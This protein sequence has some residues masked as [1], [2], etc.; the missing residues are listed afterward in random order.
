M[1][2]PLVA[3]VKD[4]TT[5][6][7]GVPLLEDATGL[8]SAIESKNWAA[9]AIGAVGTALDVLTAVLDPFGAIFA[10]GVGWLM[11]HVGPLKEALDAL[12]GNADEIE[13]HAETWANVAKELEGV[14]AELSD[15]V[16]K[17]L[18]SWSGD[19]A[20]AYRAQADDVS[21]LIS[22]AQK[23]CEGA[24]S[25]VK[26]AGEIVA[27]VRSLVRDTIADLVGHLISWALQVVF[28]LGIGM[29]WVVPQVVTAVAKT[30]SK[31]TSVTTKLVKAMKALMPLLKKAGSLFED[32]GKALKGLKGGKVKAPEKPKDIKSGSPDPKPH[33]KDEGTETAG[34]KGGGS[35]PGGPNQDTHA[36]GAGGKN[37]NDHNGGGSNGDHHQDGDHTSTSGSETGGPGGK[38]PTDP[39]RTAEDPDNRPCLTDP[40]DLSSGEVIFEAIDLD[41]PELLVERVHLSSYR[42][43]HWFGPSWAST[44]DQR[45][46][47]DADGV[48]YFGPNGVILVYPRP[49][50]GAPVLPVEG[51]RWPLAQHEDG[52]F[53]IGQASLGRT[54]RFAG[55]V[56]LLREIDDADGSQTR[57]SYA[58]N[59][60]PTRLAHSSGLQVGF[61]TDAGRVTELR[62]I[63]DGE[64]SDVVVRSY[65]YNAEGRLAEVVNSSGKPLRFD[66]DR[67]GRLTGW[68]DRN[69]VWY[70]YVYDAEGRCVRTVGDRGFFDGAFEYDREAR[71]TRFTD[72]LGHVSEYECNPEGKVVRETDPLGHVTRS[73]WERYGKL[74][75]RTDPLGQTTSFAYDERG[76]LES[77]T[78][79]DGS[80]LRVAEDAGGLTIE[81]DAE[82]GTVLSRFYPG[83][84]APDPFTETLGIARALTSAQAAWTRGPEAPAPADR[85]V[86]GRPRSVLN[87][88]QRD[89]VLGWTVDGSERLRV[90]PSGVRETRRYDAEGN[91]VEH[92]NGA[93]LAERTEYG[94]FDLVT[95]TIDPSGARTS[96][97]YDTELRPVTVTNPLGQ[98]WT[99]RY[100]PAGRLVEE[101]DFD[102]RTLRFGYDAAGRLAWSADG[103]GERTEYGYDGLGNVVE[104]RCPAGTTRFAYDAVGRMTGAGEADVELRVTY[105]GE[106]NVLSESVDGRTL[107]CTHS[108]DGTVRWRTPSGVDSVWTFDGN[109]RPASL[110][111]AGHTVRF[112]HDAGGREISRT[113]DAGFALTQSFD[114]DDNLVGQS[115]QAAGAPP[116]R[117]RFSYRPDGLLTGI[118]DDVTGP[119][120]LVLDAAGRVA[121]VHGTTGRETYRYDPAGNV[122][123]TREPGHG[124][125]AG[126]RRYEKN[127]LVSAGAVSFEHDVCGRVVTRSEGG[128]VWKYLWDGQDRL[129]AVVTPEG[130]H[131]R[132]RY[133]PI[134]R[135]IGKQ[136]VVTSATGARVA[137]ESYEFTWSGA[138]LV[139]QVYVDPSQTRHVTV[140]AHH[141]D[142]DRPV[143]QVERSATLDERFF[144]IVTDLIGRPTD[145]VDAAGS[146]VWHGNA[147]LWGGETGAAA[148]PL[149]FPGQYADAES[150]LHYNLYRYYDPSTG[151]YLSQDPLGLGPA[152]NPAAYVGNP[153]AD[154]D[155]LGL[156][157]GKKGAGGKAKT[158]DRPGGG[159]SAGNIPRKILDWFRKPFK[160]KNPDQPPPHTD[161][162][163]PPPPK[164]G[165]QYSKERPMR[166]NYEHETDPAREPFPG[167]S[168]KRL[169]D[170]QR[171]EH[172]VYLD[173]SGKM[174]NAKDGTLF[175]TSN[176]TDIH[177][178]SGD[179]RAIFTMDRHGNIYASNYQ[180]AGDF[181][182]STLANGQP[183][184][185]AGEL[186]V[187]NGTVTHVNNNSG[188]YQPQLDQSQNIYDEFKSHGIDPPNFGF[189]GHQL[190]GPGG[191]LR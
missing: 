99:Y 138:L 32:A 148:T 1:S 78:R 82:D 117:R 151:R 170:Q 2:N 158:K 12:T 171:E 188:H 154:R 41:L 8:K 27:A 101:T 189:G 119:T 50:V 114:A 92:V 141:P 157:C 23:G 70:R 135:R 5:A 46:E 122:L 173:S 20:D 14:A 181:H 4:S 107:T 132:Y 90:R 3:P 79:P 69:G 85:D 39:K 34:D 44:L 160:K 94:P 98:S 95:A 103:A 142:D 121:E 43:G 131:W 75:A 21:K 143:V 139:E 11:E 179:G 111:I 65:R 76:V 130:E 86:F 144:A 59:G 96:H 83:D 125:S 169:N 153:L 87:R 61:R 73:T 182:H 88:S 63:G 93:G 55:P 180:G 28:T 133:D 37:E 77:V 19:A 38:G 58:A 26:T 31:I 97:T 113:V 120:R 30:A 185:A 118:D 67:Q 42:S 150:G 156:A 127:R 126:V 186:T 102:G 6:A 146:P 29:A 25:G 108:D 161:P 60:A 18:Q 56:L 168:V 184:S 124:P 49:A 140:W 109:G 68:Q 54:L 166:D 40:V 177:H 17:D 172:R 176:A 155:L 159:T 22:S 62:M 10:A 115:V 175:D 89:V 13:A 16:K 72:S 47:A 123:E 64:S 24:G 66:Y 152:P 164:S 183:V 45:L 187:K 36:S 162:N 35:G 33:P 147:G 74:L 129:L 134:G 167:Q 53:T 136:R 128:R 57:L 191:I 190:N 100:D 174:R 137:A 163:P 178:E 106:G 112:E 80:V 145:L 84:E 71:I 9:V 52:S 165:N 116:R 81:A 104:R 91:E 7:S 149:R 15:V 51:A 48:R 105:D 110:V